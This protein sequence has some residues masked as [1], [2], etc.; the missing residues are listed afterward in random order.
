MQ[1]SGADKNH[2]TIRVYGFDSHTRRRQARLRLGFRVKPLRTSSCTISLQLVQGRCH[3]SFSA[4][5]SP[6]LNSTHICSRSQRAPS[7]RP[8]HEKLTMLPQSH[9]V[10]EPV[11]EVRWQYSTWISNCAPKF[12]VQLPRSFGLG[13]G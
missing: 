11:F 6:P 12:S 5:Q 13:F 7:S 4:A 2:K 1:G 10:T 8:I 9:S 3:F